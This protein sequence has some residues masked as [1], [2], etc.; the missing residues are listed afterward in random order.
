MTGEEL[1]EIYAKHLLDVWG[2]ECDRWEDLAE[3]DQSAWNKVAEE[4]T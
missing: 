3:S 2:T 4:V 1:Y